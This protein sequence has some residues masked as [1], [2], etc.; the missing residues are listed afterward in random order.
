MRRFTYARKGFRVRKY[1]RYLRLFPVCGKMLGFVA[2]V[3]VTKPQ[4]ARETDMVVK[5]IG[6][7]LCV[8]HKPGNA[9]PLP[10]DSVDG[11]SHSSDP[12]HPYLEWQQ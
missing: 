10:S 5:N 9:I 7:T 3:L 1:R 11:N 4:T 2:G 12:S 6:L 8:Q